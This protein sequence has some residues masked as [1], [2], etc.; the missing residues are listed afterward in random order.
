MMAC[1]NNSERGFI[2]TT[3]VMIG[4]LLIIWLGIW[5]YMNTVD[6]TPTGPVPEE[7]AAV[8]ATGGSV[9]VTLEGGLIIEDTQVGAGDEAKPGMTLSMHYTGTLDDGTV[10]DS[11][12]TRNQPFEF[13][14][15]SGQVIQG[16][17]KGI[18]GMKVGGERKLTIPPAMGY[19]SNSA[20]SIPPNST[21]H[22]EVELLGVK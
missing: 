14:L 3:V 1:M 12:R 15:G 22:F 6:N 4:V 13:T 17:E 9:P 10:F 8:P 20:G 2:G 7:S 5:W 16:W 11:S 18:A 19:G 21:L